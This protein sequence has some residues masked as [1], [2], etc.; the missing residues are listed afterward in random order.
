MANLVAGLYV[1][2]LLGVQGIPWEG[3]NV[4]YG[5]D[6]A[7]RETAYDG[8]RIEYLAATPKPGATLTQGKPVEFVVRVRYSL[9]QAAA[10]RLLV[11]LTGRNGEL[12]NAEGA[13]VQVPQAANAERTVTFATTI[14]AS[15][16]DLV[17]HVGVAPRDEQRAV[18]DLRI[19]YAVEKSR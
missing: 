13:A 2:C 7:R 9:Q 14:P 4:S 19:R 6:D 12:L 10:G 18:R 17:L 16:S 1:A 15:P 8:M 5:P 3:P 11:W